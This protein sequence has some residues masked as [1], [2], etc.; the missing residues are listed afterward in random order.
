MRRMTELQRRGRRELVI[1]LTFIG[2]MF[3]PGPLSHAWQAR[4]DWSGL[5]SAFETLVI[6]LTVGVGVW[7]GSH[8]L[9]RVAIAWFG[10]IGAVLLLGGILGGRQLVDHSAFAKLEGIGFHPFVAYYGIVAVNLVAAFALAYS[11]PI[12][13]YWD[14]RRDPKGKTASDKPPDVVSGPPLSCGEPS[15]PKGDCCLSCGAPLPEDVER[16]TACGWTF[17]EAR[18]VGSGTGQ[19]PRVQADTR[20]LNP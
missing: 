12:H 15:L 3:L 10:G 18:A 7:R 4:H 5:I 1:L 6:V 20:T 14:Y 16:C 11:A 17:T 19:E 2:V 9:R 8:A 13:A